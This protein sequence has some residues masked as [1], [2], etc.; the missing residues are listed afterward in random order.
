MPL[1]DAGALGNRVTVLEGD[2]EAE[3]LAAAAGVVTDTDRR[4]E[5]TF[6]YMRGN[7]SATMTAT[8]PYVQSRTVHDYRVAGDAGS[9]V[10]V[11]GLEFDASSSPSDVDATWRQPRGATPAAAMD[12]A[13]DTYWRPGAL[14]EEGSYWEVRYEEPV[15]LGDTLDVALLNRGTKIDTTIPL[16]ITTD[17]GTTTAD[18]RDRAIVADGSGGGGSHILRPDR[19]GRRLPSAALGHPGGAIA[20]GGD[21]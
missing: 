11:P 5:V 7:E 19:D 15:E 1:A 8:Q 13:M 21:Q 14:N 9:T 6:G 20:G 2:P 18:A 4:R 17:N 16:E 12:G 10:A 3:D